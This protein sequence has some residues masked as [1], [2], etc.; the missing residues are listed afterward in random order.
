MQ[1]QEGQGLACCAGVTAADCVR[2][3]R[4]CNSSVA[5]TTGSDAIHPTQSRDRF[6]QTRVQTLSFS[7]QSSKDAPPTHSGP[8]LVD[9]ARNPPRR[10]VC[11]AELR[12]PAIWLVNQMG[13]AS[14]S[15]S[16]LAGRSIICGSA[17]RRVV[18]RCGCPSPY[19]KRLVA[20][21]LPKR[22]ARTA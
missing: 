21:H 1:R 3:G 17:V 13:A 22:R 20:S 18:G 19:G 11:R 2:Q 6:V 5:F 9:R 8:I 16:D 12:R 7:I 14:V 4:V 10:P 15:V